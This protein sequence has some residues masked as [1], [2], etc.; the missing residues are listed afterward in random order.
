MLKHSHYKVGCGAHPGLARQPVLSLPKGLPWQ[1]RGQAST[2][3]SLQCST[4]KASP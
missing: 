1:S 3:R 2:I 4:G